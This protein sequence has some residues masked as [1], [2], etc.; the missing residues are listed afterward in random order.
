VPF[1]GEPGKAVES[2]RRVSNHGYTAWTFV[3]RVVAP[4]AADES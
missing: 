3:S 4:G 1:H 2:G